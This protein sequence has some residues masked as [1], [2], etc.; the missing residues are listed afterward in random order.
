MYAPLSN[1]CRHT[2]FLD[3]FFLN[4]HFKKNFQKQ[5]NDNFIF[6]FIIFFL[7]TTCKSVLAAHMA[8]NTVLENATIHKIKFLG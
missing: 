3:V 2:E 8:I 4:I 7:K 6:H 1:E 5:T